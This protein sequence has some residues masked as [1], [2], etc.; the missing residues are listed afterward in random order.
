MKVG[1]S[2]RKRMVR[3]FMCAALNRPRSFVR[4]M[5]NVVMDS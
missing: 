5:E 3:A 2:E 1:I 4:E